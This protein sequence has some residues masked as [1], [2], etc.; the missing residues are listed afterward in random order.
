MDLV[1]AAVQRDIVLLLAVIVVTLGGVVSVLF[2]LLVKEKTARVTRAES[3]TD[4]MGDLFDK[5]ETS[6]ST[7]VAVARDNAKVAEKAADLAQQSL[8]ELRAR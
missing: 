3:L 8:N 7:A 1:D 2:W 6:T 4:R 5:L